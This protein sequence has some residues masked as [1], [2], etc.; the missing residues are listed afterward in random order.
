MPVSDLRPPRHRS[1]V[2]YV[3]DELRRAISAGRLQQGEQ[4]GEAELA[5]QLDVSRGPL[6]E[7]MQRLVAEGLLDAIRN[8]GVFVTELS[9][10]DVRDIYRTRAVIERAAL[11]LVLPEAAAATAQ[12]LQP[13]VA[14]MRTAARHGRASAVSDADQTFHEALVEAS[15]SPRLIRAMRTL[16]V[17]S[18]MCLG[19]LETT[20]DDLGLQVREHGELLQA[21]REGTLEQAEKSLNE[22]MDDAVQRLVSKRVPPA[23]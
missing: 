21:I 11:E 16:V 4:L 20:Y 22:H 14:A 7:A 13:S 9:L 10:D 1:T 23:S 18:R 8:R 12:S 17:E 19:E 3:A 5:L 6:R 2:E 15:G